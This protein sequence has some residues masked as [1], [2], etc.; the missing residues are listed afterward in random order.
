MKIPR[1][2]ERFRVFN[3]GKFAFILGKDAD[4]NEELVKRHASKSPVIAH[5]FVDGSPFGIAIGELPE[6]FEDMLCSLVACYSRAWKSG[7]GM[8]EAYW[9]KPEQVSKKA[10]AGEYLSKGS[11][12]VYG[13]KNTVKAEL[14][15][16]FCNSAGRLVVGPEGLVSRICGK[17]VCITPGSMKARD[18]AKLIRNRIGR[19]I[20]LAD[21]EKYIPY[22]SCEVLV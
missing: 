6:G 8:V 3:Y 15:L 2:M 22:G 14:K 1:S 18:A 7:I 13:R 5:A 12:M 20:G 19:E 11:F 4:T 10:P 16:C 21:I 17:Y 9:V